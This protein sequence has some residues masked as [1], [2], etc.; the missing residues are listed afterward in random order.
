MAD[1]RFWQSVKRE[2][3]V[4][5]S[6]WTYPMMI[7]ALPA[8]VCLFF[9]GL[10]S[11]GLPLRVPTAIVDMDDSPMSRSAI[12][13]LEATELIEV[14]DLCISYDEAM[15]KIR[16]GEIYGFFMIPTDFEKDAVSGRIP[17]IEYYNNLTYFIPGTLTFKGFK[18][19]AVTTSVGMA[20]AKLVYA[21]APNEMV[22]EFLQPMTV[23]IH[24]IGNPWMNYSAYLS[25][26]FTFG[27]LALLIMLVT[28]YGITMELK[29]GTSREWLKRAN[30][31]IS[32]A[33]T[34]KLLAQFVLWCISSILCISILFGYAGLPCVNVLTMAFATMLF[35]A[36][37][38]GLGLLI[39]SLL[40]NPRLAMSV[41]ALFSI[42][43]F[44]FTGISFPVQEMYGSIAIFS[45]ISPL[46][47]IFLIFV[48]S[49]LNGFPIYYARLSFVALLIFPIA[50][51][52]FLSR[53]KRACQNP[54]Y[55]A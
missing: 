35:V 7:L 49:G 23:N 11:P 43:S 34:A 47:H 5:S 38:Q 29:Y 41:A 37:C 36:A 48:N 30:G 44:S 18:T 46:R 54:I 4:L 1:L 20:K 19:I 25:P 28:V 27:V 33:V 6:N 21:G 52:L 26:S 16:S 9:I 22:N 3:R 45:Y 42:L 55:I 14:I 51:G 50:G 53:L 32:V 39:C 31:S 8:L 10:L 15:D 2:V 13:S 12:R 24:P 40:P 17:S